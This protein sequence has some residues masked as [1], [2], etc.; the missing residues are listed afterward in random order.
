MARLRYTCVARFRRGHCY[1]ERLR[2]QSQPT[3]GNAN[4]GRYECTLAK[5]GAAA[6]TQIRLPQTSA[7]C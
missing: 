6:V 3:M 1:A 4:A 7:V 2:G 5:C